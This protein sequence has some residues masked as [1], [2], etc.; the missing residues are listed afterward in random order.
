MGNK[1]ALRPDKGERRRTVRPSRY[2]LVSAD[3]SRRRPQRAPT[4]PGSVTGT[5]GDRY[6]RPNMSGVSQSRLARELPR[7]H[8]PVRTS[9]RLSDERNRTYFPRSMPYLSAIVTLSVHDGTR[10]RKEQESEE[11]DYAWQVVG[12]AAAIA[13][14]ILLD[15]IPRAIVHEPGLAGDLLPVAALLSVADLIYVQSTCGNGV[16][17]GSVITFVSRVAEYVAA[18]AVFAVYNASVNL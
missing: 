6:L 14:G 5:P 11:T 18:G 10:G 9:H 7:T 12:M 16:S 13:A 3:A 15:A 2:H 4:R 1:N 8:T 17:Q